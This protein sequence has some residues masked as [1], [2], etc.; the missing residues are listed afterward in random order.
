MLT[1]P[2]ANSNNQ[3]RPSAL[4]RKPSGLTPL[5]MS[6]GNKN[7]NIYARGS[8]SLAKKDEVLTDEMLDKISFLQAAIKKEFKDDIG[9]SIKKKGNNQ[10]V[11][12]DDGNIV[13]DY[14]SGD[15]IEESALN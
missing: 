9:K 5:R 2:K 14:F 13:D 15:N 3:P 7:Q 11:Q 8:V 6:G 12:E 1:R 10:I 4:K